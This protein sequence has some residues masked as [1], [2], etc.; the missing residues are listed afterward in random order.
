M[1]RIDHE[2]PAEE[3]RFDRVLPAGA[4]PT[5]KEILLDNLR[6]TKVYWL[7]REARLSAEPRSAINRF[8]CRARSS[9][10]IIVTKFS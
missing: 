8:L 2:G 9:P 5:S 6:N 1:K 4:M 7:I 10:F 3:Q